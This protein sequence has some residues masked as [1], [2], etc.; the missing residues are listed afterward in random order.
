AGAAISV[1]GPSGRGKSTLAVALARS[2]SG[3]GVLHDDL[4]VL[5]GDLVARPGPRRAELVADATTA[6]GIP[7]YGPETVVPLDAC[8]A[9][10]L[11]AVVLREPRGSSPGL[12]ALS[13]VDAAA[14]LGQDAGWWCVLT[15]RGQSA[16]FAH[17]A[18]LARSVPCVAWSPP[19]GIAAAAAALD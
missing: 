9:A 18:Q 13:V 7:S 8:G 12:R 5:T 14:R 10:P 2:G 3:W 6:L 17:L 15:P 11:T 4:T 19:H 1:C 16:R